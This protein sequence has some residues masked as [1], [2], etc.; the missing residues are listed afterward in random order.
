MW[1]HII[2]FVT[3]SCSDFHQSSRCSITEYHVWKEIRNRYIE[4]QDACRKI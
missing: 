4:I 1:S 2:K 3:A